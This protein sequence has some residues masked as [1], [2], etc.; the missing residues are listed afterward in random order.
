MVSSSGWR[1]ISGI[2]APATANRLNSLAISP[3]DTHIVTFQRR[4][5]S[6]GEWLI[7][8]ESS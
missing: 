4:C 3:S 8:Q 7:S 2:L 6:L 1:T 5:Q